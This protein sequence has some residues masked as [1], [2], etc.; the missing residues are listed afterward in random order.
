MA[1]QISKFCAKC[2]SCEMECPAG[3]V[4]LDGIDYTI[5]PALCTGCGHCA[6]I[7]PVSAISDSEK[8][9]RPAAHQPIVIDA[10]LCVIGGGGGGMVAAVKFAQLTGKKAV[11]L[12]KAKKL[13]E[14]PIWLTALGP[15][16]PKCSGTRGTR[17][18]G[19]KR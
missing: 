7:C 1:Y 4:Y 6:E 11:V 5:D 10:D 13:E 16:T 18:R 14:I 2:H 8:P 12:E 15:F 3:A 9:E 19:K 17:T